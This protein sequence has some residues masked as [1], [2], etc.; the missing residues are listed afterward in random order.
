M[1]IKIVLVIEENYGKLET[2][3]REF[4]GNLRPPEQFLE[5]NTFSSLLQKVSTD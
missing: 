5:Q 4:A 2:E 1:S 3:G